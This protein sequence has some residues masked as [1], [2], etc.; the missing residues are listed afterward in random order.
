MRILP[1]TGVFLQFLLTVARRLKFDTAE[2]VPVRTATILSKCIK[3]VLEVYKRADF[4]VKTILMDGEFEKIKPHLP[5][6]ECNTTAAKE[7]VSKAERTI[8]TLKERTRGLMAMLPF[9]HILRRMKIKFVY[10]IV[11]WLNAFPVK[12]GILATYSPRELILRWRLDY[13][14]HCRMLPGTYCDT[15]RARSHKHDGVAYA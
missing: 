12:S 3:Q 10:F 5:T 14:K 7:H 15:R 13:K 6:V 8:R 11:L 1:P 2:H 9:S 4:I